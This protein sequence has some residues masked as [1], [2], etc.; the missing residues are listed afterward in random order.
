MQTP[1]LSSLTLL[2]GNSTRMGRLKQHVS[3]AGVPFLQRIIGKLLAIKQSLHAMVFVGQANDQDSQSLVADSGGIWLSNPCP[4][5]GPLS[6]IRLGL[7]KIDPGSAILLWPVDHP[8]IAAATL[9][10]LIASWQQ[11]PELITVP[12]DGQRRGHPGIYPAWCRPLFFEIDLAS[13]ARQIMQLHPD[14][15]Q[16]LLTDDPW[17]TR[18]LNTPEALADAEACLISEKPVRQSSE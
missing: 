10:G 4:A 1:L 12:S 18:N 8:M 7:G 14:R 13:G 16:H 11:Q 2:A 5:D 3:L 6:S 17:I 15:I 9:E